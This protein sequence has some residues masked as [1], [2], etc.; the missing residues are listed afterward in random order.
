MSMKIKPPELKEKSYERYKQE[1]LAWREI[2]DLDKEKQSIAIA[3]SFPE[4]GANGIREKVFDELSIDQLKHENGLD[5]LIEFLDD[6]LKTDDLAD[7]W[8]KF[9]DFESF[10]RDPD[11]K[12]SDYISKF[13]QKYNKIAKKGM[14]IVPEILAFKLLKQSNISDDERL[15]VLTGMNY[16]NKATLYEEA[17][18][19]LKKFKGDQSSH[20]SK[21]DSV[22]KMEPTLITQDE[23]AL[24]AAGYIHKSQ[25]NS[26]QNRGRGRSSR[27]RGRGQWQSSRGSNSKISNGSQ[28][29]SNSRPLN[30][31]GTDGKILTCVACGSFRHLLASCPDSWENMK[32]VK[33]TD[34]VPCLFTG[35]LPFESHQLQKEATNCAVLDS[36]C[37]STV[38]GKSWLESY[39]NSLEKSTKSKILKMESSKT[40][41][42][43]GGEK[44][45][46]LGCYI[47]PAIIAGIEV[48]IKTDVV[49]S[50]IPLLLSL[51]AMKDAKIKLD[52]EN[53]S[54]E[55]FGKQVLL[56][57]TS[58][59]HYCIPINWTEIEI[60][61]VCAVQLDTL[62]KSTRYNTLLK[63]HRQFAH[64]PENK[65]ISLLK[66]AG[67]WNEKFK[68]DLVTISKTCKVC[69]IYKK[70]PPRPIVGLPMARK[71]NEKVAMDLKS[72]KDKWILHI[73]DM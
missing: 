11:Q 55:I 8:E 70:T 38:C 29:A 7:S 51:N 22:I 33:I 56:N 35:G 1:L 61:R 5:I 12:I 27:G 47:L 52:L 71:F 49:E 4:D 21:T 10:S 9:D 40:F 42:F 15:L 48:K 59:G 66:D 32:N 28:G 31:V 73:V 25:I 17:K 18:S 60:E 72:W 39:I 3:L 37:S 67:I 34:D 45:P 69:T 13:D 20:K 44:L 41:K 24:M 16:N 14:K 63:L 64:P 50:E 54:A 26:Y 68:E 65:L 62:D 36:A 58:S 43:G 46:S 19:S 23:E 30:P 2:T 6:K 57:H 53:D